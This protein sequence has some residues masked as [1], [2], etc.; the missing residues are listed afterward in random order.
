MLKVMGKTGQF[1][2]PNAIFTGFDRF[3]PV[4]FI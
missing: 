2:V 4:H 3:K 1:D